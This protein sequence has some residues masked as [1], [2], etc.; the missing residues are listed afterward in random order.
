[1]WDSR[2]SFPGNSG[3]N[4]G[5]E[6]SGSVQLQLPSGSMSSELIALP[7]QVDIAC[8][9]SVAFKA[10]CQL[11]VLALASYTAFPRAFYVDH[12]SSM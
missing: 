2:D 10:R 4:A 7:L 12:Y 5:T 3:R 11:L 1:M 8:L 9:G 6:G